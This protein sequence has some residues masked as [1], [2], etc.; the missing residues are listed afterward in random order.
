MTDRAYNQLHP[1]LQFLSLIGNLVG[2][3][4]AMALYGVNTVMAIAQMNFTLP[5][6]LNALWIIQ[7]AG[8][9]LPIFAAPVFFAYVVV[10]DPHDYIKPSFRFPWELFPVVLIIMFLSSPSIEVLSNINEKLKLPQYLSGVQ[11]WME[12]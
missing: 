4:L 6:V 7:I 1:A 5:H 9:T 3:G 8:T 2:I 10:R 11:K 12:D